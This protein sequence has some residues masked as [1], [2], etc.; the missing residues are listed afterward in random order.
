MDKLDKLLEAAK[1]AAREA[2]GLLKE[3]VDKRGEIMFKGV[4]DLVTLFDKQSQDLIFRRLSA[5]FPEHGLVWDFNY[6]GDLLFLQHA[7]AQATARHLHLED[8]WVYFIHGWTQVIAEVF[9]IEIP[10]GGPGFEELSRI[11][12]AARGA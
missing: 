10:S 12:A 3:N 9:H 1:A 8:G 7:K 11:A 5:A 2:G 6:R 4:V